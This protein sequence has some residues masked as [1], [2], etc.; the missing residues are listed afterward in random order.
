MGREE[1]DLVSASQIFYPCMQCADIFFLEADIC[2][3]GEDQREVNMLAREYCVPFGRKFSPIILSHP[4]LAGVTGELSKTDPN[5]AIFM[6][7]T[8]TDVNTKIKKACCVPGDVTKNPCLEYVKHLVME[9]DGKFLVERKE[10]NGGNKL[11]E[12]YQ[13]VEADF[14]SLALHPLDL[15]IALSKAINAM[16]QPVRDHFKTGQPAVLLKQVKS[17]RATK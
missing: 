10:E 5:A 3:L 14:I 6:E 2:Q 9:K 16:L 8:E 4:M 1:S 7:D 12:K 11:Y 17:Y 13:D 15:K